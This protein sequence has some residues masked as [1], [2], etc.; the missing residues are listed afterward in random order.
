MSTKPTN[1]VEA[2]RYFDDLDTATEF[3]A[4]IRWP[5]GPLCPRCGSGDYSYLTTRRLWKCKACA[6]QYSVKLGTFFE[7]S[8]IGLNKWLPAVWAV[9]NDDRPTTRYLAH[10]LGVTQKS[11]W[12]MLQRVQ[13]AVRTG[14]YERAT[15]GGSP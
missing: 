5:D 11:A 4:K 6:K 13:A 3:I 12:L 2:V 14:S 10:M 8:P 1:L 15:N 7:G 9:A